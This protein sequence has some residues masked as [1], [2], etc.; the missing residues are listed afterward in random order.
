MACSNIR[1]GVGVTAEVGMDVVNLGLKNICVVTDKNVSSLGAQ[2]QKFQVAHT[3][4]FLFP[5][6]VI[7]LLACRH[8]KLCLTLYMPAMYS[9]PCTTTSP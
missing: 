1:Y 5:L 2:I 6:L 8:F 3:S 9:I 4:M 7:S